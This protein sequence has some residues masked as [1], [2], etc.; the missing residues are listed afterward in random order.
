ML[1]PIDREPRPSAAVSLA[2][3]VADSY[4]CAD[5]LVHLLHVGAADAAPTISIDAKR[6]QRL[7]RHTH[8][9][10]VTDAIVRFADE[11]NAELIVMPTLGRDGFLDAL[12]GST[13]ERVLRQARRP[14]LAVPALGG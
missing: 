4:G 11:L 1:I 9:G 3:E 10:T 5:A 2:F 6:D 14:L 12:R 13:T 7:R 8:Q